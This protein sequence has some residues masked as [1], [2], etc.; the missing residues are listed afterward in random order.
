LHL[1]CVKQAERFRQARPLRGTS[2]SKQLIMRD[3]TR[4]FK[5][6]AAKI[7]KRSAFQIA[8]QNV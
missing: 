8:K 2:S 3:A 1:Q 4:I 5:L 6:N 7:E